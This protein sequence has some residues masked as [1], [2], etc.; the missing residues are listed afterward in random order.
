[1]KHERERGRG[2][3]ALTNPYVF[4]ASEKFVDFVIYAFNLMNF[5]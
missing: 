1:M 3:R 5:F 4:V 2:G